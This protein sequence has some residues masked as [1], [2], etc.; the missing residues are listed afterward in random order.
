M[1]QLRFLRGPFLIVIAW[2]LFPLLLPQLLWSHPRGGALLLQALLVLLQPIGFC[3]NILLLVTGCLFCVHDILTTTSVS[4]CFQRILQTWIQKYTSTIVLDK[5]LQDIFGWFHTVGTTLLANFT[6][7]TCL[8]STPEERTRILQTTLTSTTT[9]TTTIS[10]QEAQQILHEPGGLTRYLF[11]T[12]K[13]KQEDV[14]KSIRQ[15]NTHIQQSIHHQNDA[16]RIQSP[17][18][19]D[20]TTQPKP[21]TCTTES[22]VHGTDGDPLWN[23]IRQILGNT[24]Q[25]KQRHIQNKFSLPSCLDEYPILQGTALVSLLALMIQLRSS[26]RARNM[27]LNAL[28]GSVSLGLGTLFGAATSAWLAKYAVQH[29]QH[30]SLLL[31]AATNAQGGLCITTQRLSQSKF[32]QKTKKLWSKLVKQISTKKVQGAI[33]LLILYYVGSRRRQKTVTVR[34]Y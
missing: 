24:M 29:P 12:E 33:A 11:Q 23:V 30:V 16:R 31:A 2:V 28:H 3:G 4:S 22:A 25:N 9:T 14:H 26:S 8:D 5:L 6:L 34:Q 21:T 18:E 13:L 15:D 19:L 27:A 10:Y 7:Y 32:V 1:I 20:T 17:P